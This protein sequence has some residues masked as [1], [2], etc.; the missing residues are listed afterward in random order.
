MN[1]TP[2][3]LKDYDCPL[4][5]NRGYIYEPI[6]NEFYHYWSASAHKCHCMNIRE[7]IARRRSS[8]LKK[9]MQ[10][11]TFKTYKADE[12]WQLEIAKSACTYVRN[13]E[14]WF[15]IGGQPGCGKTHICTAIVNAL[16]TKGYA[17]R[18]MVW[19]EE[20]TSIKQ[21][22]TESAVYDGLIKG[23]QKAEILYIDD[24]FK[25]AK[26]Y[27]M[28]ASDINTTFKIINYRYNEDLPTIISSELSIAEIIEL[29]EA[30]GSRIAEMTKGMDFYIAK[31]SSKNY[32]Y[33]NVRA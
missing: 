1:S 27:S 32:R 30:L 17:A 11:Y 18:Y 3:K 7:E 20:I 2:G 31:D 19:N 26:G 16:I 10:K 14:G 33:R 23:L 25:T 5:M 29:D 12:P 6:E 24:F 22:A 9:V 15:F 8:G 21:A 28:T 13:P 4:C